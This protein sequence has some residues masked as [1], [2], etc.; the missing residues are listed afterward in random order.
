MIPLFKP[1]VTD[2][3]IEAVTRVL[4]SGWWALGPEVEAFEKDFAEYLRVQA[5]AAGTRHQFSTSPYAVGVNSCTSALELAARSLGVEKGTVVVPALTFVSTGQAMLHAQNK[6]VFADIDETTMCLDWDDA[7]NTLESATARRKDAPK[8]IVPVWYAGRVSLPPALPEG[9]TVIEDCAHAAGTRLAGTVGHAAAWSFQ[10]VKNLAVGD[11]GM[12]TTT[13]P[14]AYA[15][16][17]PLRWCGIDRSTWERDNKKGYNWDYDIPVDGEK[18]HL[19]DIAAALGRVQLSRLNEMND[20]RF[21]ILKQYKAGFDGLSWLK[22]RE[23]FSPYESNHLMTV[24]INATNRDRFI[25][26]MLAHGVSAGVHYKPITYYK[27]VFPN[28]R[29]LPVT[30]K[31]WRELVTLPLYPDLAWDDVDKITGVV[32]AFSPVREGA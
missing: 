20:A 30:E 10:A 1:S 4:K 7:L 17:K 31:V 13:D 18:A 16:L 29:N 2:R 6:V 3:E 11:G 12:V 9:I 26:H 23:D 24:R 21:Q 8:A 22:M 25:D 32:R 28:A 27:G 15:K 14:L 19:N 5:H